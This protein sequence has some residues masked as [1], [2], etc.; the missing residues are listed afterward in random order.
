MYGTRRRRRILYNDDAD[1]Q[2][3]RTGN[4]K[5]TKYVQQQPDYRYGARDIQAFINA[6]TTPVF[7]THVDTYVWCLGNGSDPAW[8]GKRGLV[9]GMHS[10]QQATDLIVQACHD[11]GIEVWGSL[12]MNDVHDAS[13]ATSLEEA[14]DPI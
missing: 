8:G 14:D 10:N 2:Y 9:A 3:V 1:Q 5:N 6:R 7:D 13:L 12:R 11:Q 4:G